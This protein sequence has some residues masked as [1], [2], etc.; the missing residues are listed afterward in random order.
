MSTHAEPSRNAFDVQATP[1][2]A[3]LTQQLHELGFRATR[4]RIDILRLVKSLQHPTA[5]TVWAALDAPNVAVTTVYRALQALEDAG[6]VE[7][8]RFGTGPMVYHA[9]DQDRHDHLACHHCGNLIDLPTV[10]ADPL[11]EVMTATARQQP[12]TLARVLVIGV[13]AC[14]TCQATNAADR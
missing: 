5:E 4:Q 14:A 2:S 10:R 7:S 9:T 1:D 3:D 12:F 13:G 11:R 8:D 6:V